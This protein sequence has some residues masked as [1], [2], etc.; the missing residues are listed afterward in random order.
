MKLLVIVTSY[1]CN[2]FILFWAIDAVL[3]PLFQPFTLYAFHPTL[4]RELAGKGPLPR[5]L[6]AGLEAACW[7]RPYRQATLPQLV[8]IALSL[9]SKLEN[10]AR[11]RHLSQLT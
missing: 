9:L 10:E 11:A 4:F 7:L 8:A 3:S 1:L 5:A 6:S 2:I